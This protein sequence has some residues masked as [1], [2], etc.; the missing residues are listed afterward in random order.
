MKGGN[1]GGGAGTGAGVN[2]EMAVDV[3]VAVEESAF[4]RLAA[5]ILPRHPTQI[6]VE[7]TGQRPPLWP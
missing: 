1:W 7:C 2:M 3:A 5:C 6:P 4:E